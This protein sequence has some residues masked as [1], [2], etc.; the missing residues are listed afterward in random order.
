MAKMSL[1]AIPPSRKGDFSRVQLG[2]G[3]LVRKPFLVYTP[4]S[5]R[6]YNGLITLEKSLS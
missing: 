5:L 2:E 1:K 6:L 4:N 3:E